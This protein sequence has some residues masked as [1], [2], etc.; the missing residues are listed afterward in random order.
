MAPI[1]L[2]AVVCAKGGV[3]YDSRSTSNGE[4]FDL[5]TKFFRCHVTNLI[6]KKTMIFSYAI[7]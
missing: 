3:T 5:N 2:D 7:T 6:E 4:K 1:T